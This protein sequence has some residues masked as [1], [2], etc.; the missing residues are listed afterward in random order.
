M[1][2]LKFSNTGHVA[3]QAADGPFWLVNVSL[4][5]MYAANS[6]WADID[7]LA[8]L[9]QKLSGIDS[10]VKRADLGTQTRRVPT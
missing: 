5:A 4:K 10:G 1:E 6:P 3:L 9:A 2:A 8:D 7:F